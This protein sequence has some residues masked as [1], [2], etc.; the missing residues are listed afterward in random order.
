MK[1]WAAVTCRAGQGR[2][3]VAGRAGVAGGL[4][5]SSDDT[6]HQ[7]SIPICS[8]RHKHHTL[9]RPIL[10]SH[11]CCL[12]Q[13]LAAHHSQQAKPG[14]R[15]ELEGGHP[16][17]LCGVLQARCQHGD[18]VGPA[19]QQG[20]SVRG[21][22]GGAGGGQW[23]GPISQAK[24]VCSGGGGGGGSGRRRRH[25]RAARPLTSPSQP[26]SIIQSRQEEFRGVKEGQGRK[27]QHK[28][29]RHV[30]HRHYSL[31]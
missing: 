24:S 6:V 30:A 19:E 22:A 4:L 9:P 8:H 23:R 25:F 13:Q 7:D 15:R 12:A 14:D 1:L 27:K 16:A 2:S 21:G 29:L 10:T 5:Q 20:C 11:H 26:L 28:W 18:A 31:A 17:Q 3:Q